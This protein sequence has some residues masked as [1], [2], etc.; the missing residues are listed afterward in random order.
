MELYNHI[1]IPDIGLGVYKMAHGDE[2]NNAVAA[3]QFCRKQAYFN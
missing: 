3:Q 1:S 2:M